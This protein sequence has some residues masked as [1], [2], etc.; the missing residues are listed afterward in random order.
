MKDRLGIEPSVTYNETK[1]QWLAH[2]EEKPFVIV[3]VLCPSEAAA[4]ARING[5]A[6]PKVPEDAGEPVQ[7]LAAQMAK[8]AKGAVDDDA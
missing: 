7:R 8:A 5:T 3:N 1:R 6:T 2:F 4:W